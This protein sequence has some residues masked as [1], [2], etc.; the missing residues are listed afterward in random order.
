MPLKIPVM[1]TVPS[2]PALNVCGGA[3]VD[4]GA[5]MEG[6]GSGCGVEGAAA[7]V[8][9][10]APPAGACANA[11]CCPATVRLTTTIN[12]HIRR[13]PHCFFKVML[14]SKLLLFL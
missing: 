8:C 5:V 4:S 7:G 1:A 6:L 10:G 3:A 12:M 9:A 13:P 2:G 14:L 11:C